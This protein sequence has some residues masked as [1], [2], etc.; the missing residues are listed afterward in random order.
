M[1]GNV[2][3]AKLIAQKLLE[4]DPDDSGVYSL[5]AT[6]YAGGEEWSDVRLIRSA[7]REK[8]VRKKPGQSLIEV[9]GEVHEFLAADESHPRSNEIYRALSDMIMQ[10]SR[11]P[12]W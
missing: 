7:M 5:L 2:E 8:S 12:D 3:V 10:V 4:M 9:D 11:V 1:Q 6:I